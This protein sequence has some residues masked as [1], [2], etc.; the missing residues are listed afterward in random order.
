MTSLPRFSV[1][2]PVLVNLLMIAIIIGGSY[3]ALTMIREM[4]PEAR[5]NRILVTTSYPGATPAEVEKGIT[6]KIEEAIKDVKGV[7]KILSTI[8]EG[9]STIYAELRSGFKAVDQAVNDIKAAV[10]TIPEEDFPEEARETRVAKFEPR[11]PVISVALFGDLDDRTLKNLGEE[12]R[13]EVLELPDVT[14][15][16]LSGTRKD[17]VSIEVQPAKLVEF[18]LSFLDVAHAVASSNIDLPGGQVRTEGANVSVRTLGERERAA[19]LLDIIMRSDHAGSA[20]RV[21]DVAVVRDTFEDVDT[22]GR[23]NGKPAVNVTVYKTPEQDAIKIAGAVR[24]LVAGKMDRPLE[25]PKQQKLL[26]LLT[27]R[28]QLGEIYGRALSS[29]FPQQVGVEVHTDLSR[30]IEGRLELLQRNGFWGLILV[31]LSLLIFLHWRVAFW[32]MMGL[33]LAIA[34]SLICMSLLGQTLN[35]MTMF[36]LIIVLGLLVDD[37]II[38]SE[39]VYTK[40][41]QGHAPKLAAIQGAEEVTWPV[42]C[43]VVTTIVAFIPLMFIQGQI[44]DW[45]GVLPVVVCVALFASLVEAL[46]I[47]P[48]HLAHGLRLPGRVIETTGDGKSK[49]PIRGLIARVRE[50][51]RRKLRGWLVVRYE[52]ILRAAVANRYVTM[53]ALSGVLIIALGAVA[54]GHVPFVFLQK[55]DAE[56]LVV[57]VKMGVGAP[58]EETQ[59]AVEVIERAAL[60]LPELK[61]IYTLI[62]I[63]VSDDGIPSAPQSHLSQIFIELT[64]GEKRDRSSDE[65]LNEL[66]TRTADITGVRRLTFTSMQGGPGGAPI[67]LE[68]S[69]ASI[70]NLVEVSGVIQARLADFDGVEDIVD[71]F[72]AGRRE[73]QIELFESARPL[74]LTT[75]SLATQVRAAFYGFEAQKIQRGREDVKI[76]V[77]YPLEHRRRVYDIEEMRIATPSGALVPF[78]EA[79]RLTE[80]TGFASIKRRDQ[81]R[82]VTI[83]ADANTNVTNPDQVMAALETEFPKLAAQY[84]GIRFEWGGQKLE[85]K[86]SFGSLKRDF[87]AAL[88]MIYVVLAALFRTYIQPLI[89]MAVIPFG[90]IGAVAGHFVMGYPLTILSLIGLVALTGILVNDSM[91]LVTF[92]NRRV[93]DGADLFEAVIEGGKSRLRAILLTSATTVLGIAPLL[94]EQSFQA[95]FLIPMGLSISAGLVFSTVLTLLAIPSLYLI[96]NDLREWLTGEPISFT[97][98]TTT[99]ALE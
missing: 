45:M 11:W 57:N 2:N 85:T 80:G 75:E 38:V 86:R 73:V 22:F 77:R 53:A 62:G 15:V 25:R 78:K 4:L 96:V 20:V 92:V 30:F 76:M 94:A 72:D 90:L 14:D 95:K 47:L 97:P 74:G 37:A 28:D 61:T 9:Q 63:Q 13:Q 58:A 87:A 42:T 88:M 3:S 67:H 35:L 98:A 65:I 51:Q 84:P 16:V 33:L 68:I 7:E 70:E 64:A 5:P 27:G 82:T 23:F 89:V 91:V 71:D 81:Q 8:T 50:F 66:R 1:N 79:A 31:A 10:D 6:L 12:L 49:G 59:R 29:R 99:A 52:R 17:E 93:A 21:G 43:C 41:E 48:C 54:G 19:E 69:G 46:T 39:H 83:T 36:G 60:E 18:G 26:A 24:A 55:M 56:T 44:G 40:Y 34:G 32:V